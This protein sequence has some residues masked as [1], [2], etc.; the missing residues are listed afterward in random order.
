MYV[1]LCLSRAEHERIAVF[2]HHCGL[3]APQQQACSLWRGQCPPSHSD[4][5]LHVTCMCWSLSYGA[6]VVY[7]GSALHVGHVWG[8][9]CQGYRSDRI[10]DRDP[11]MQGK[12]YSASCKVS[13]TVHHARLAMQCTVICHACKAHAASQLVHRCHTQGH[14]MSC[15]TIIPFRQ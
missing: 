3:Q 14:G 13:H 11:I 4:L 10:T 7:V 8:R 2:Y 12:P 15:S 9:C 1:I 6:C 5:L